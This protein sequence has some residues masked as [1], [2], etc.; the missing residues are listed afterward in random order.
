MFA[1][2]KIGKINMQ[3]KESRSLSFEIA[4]LPSNNSVI[5]KICIINV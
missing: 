4:K 3:K 1:L 2:V 5:I